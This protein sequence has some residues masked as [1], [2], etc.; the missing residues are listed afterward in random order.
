MVDTVD[1]N[2][3]LVNNDAVGGFDIGSVD[4]E[5]TYPEDPT[6]ALL[7]S[8]Y[9]LSIFD[10]NGDLYA[11]YI[12]NDTNPLGLNVGDITFTV[13]G[14][15]LNLTSDMWE[16][17]DY[18]LE[19]WVDVTEDGNWEYTGEID[20]TVEAAP[21][22]TV[23]VL[24]PV[25]KEIDVL[26]PANNM[27]MIQIQIF[28]QNMTTFG[29]PEN[30][31]I[32]ANNTNVTERITVEGHILYKPPADLYAY[33]GDGIWN[34][35]VFPTRGNGMIYI[36][37]TW[38]DATTI[39]SVIISIDNGGFVTVDPLSV[40]VDT[41]TT[42][43]AEVK[44]NT[45]QIPFYNANVTLVYE[46]D[47]FVPGTTVLASQGQANGQGIYEFLNFTA[48]EADV[49]IIVIASFEF[50]GTQYAYGIISS[51]PAHDLGLA[52]SPGEVLAG[53]NTEFSVNVTKGNASYEDD[54]EFYIMNQTEYDMF[55]AG[56]YELG[57]PTYTGDDANDTFMYYITEPGTYYMY[58][59]TEDK[60]T[61]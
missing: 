34:I 6:L 35:P 57:T 58:V 12:Y 11:Y 59:R 49:N 9:N 55:Q 38:P 46:I 39:A 5:I 17:G 30:L 14:K 41:P 44:D 20:F 21:D 29:T 40:I 4:F 27:Q 3:T 33:G 2:I 26:D 15:T 22:V 18:T 1:G 47:T 51:D 8:W 16:A 61:R 45:E 36:N 25:S 48:D 32:G 56:E 19:I 31:D 42:V 7:A 10:E 24:S 23:K 28:G 43:E 60:K 37:V 53:E 50:G 52:M 13:L 54:F